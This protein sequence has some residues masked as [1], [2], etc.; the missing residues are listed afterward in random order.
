MAEP[1][2]ESLDNLV[3]TLAPVEVDAGAVEVALAYSKFLAGI[4]A[5]CPQVFWHGGDAV[6][7]TWKARETNWYLTL[8]DSGAAA[9]LGSPISAPPT[10]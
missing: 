5:P 9:V 10:P 1:T 2:Y 7:F 4:G 3:A 6:V 8:T